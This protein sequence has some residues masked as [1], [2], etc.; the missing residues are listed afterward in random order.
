[1]LAAITALV[2]DGSILAVAVPLLVGGLMLR[3]F[4]TPT[5]SRWRVTAE[6]GW[7][8]SLP[9][10]M[11]G[12]LEVLAAD[13]EFACR[14]VTALVWGGAGAAP[15]PETVQGILG[16]LDT[17]A[18]AQSHEGRG[19]DIRSGPISGNTGIVSNGQMV[20]RNTR[21]V[22]YVHRLVDEVLMPL[23]RSHAIARVSLT[24][25]SCSSREDLLGVRARRRGAP[26]RPEV[27]QSARR[28]SP[29][30]AGT[31][32]LSL[33]NPSETAAELRRP[34]GGR[35]AARPERPERVSCSSCASCPTFPWPP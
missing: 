3:L 31:P 8:A 12:Y 10:A 24:R 29:A 27:V 4:A 2:W 32:A 6:N 30:P 35:A 5:A 20:L 26:Q 28:I 17:D 16:V 11:E 25:E 9:F 19:V 22:P 34:P 23:H 21:L 18:R 33:S 13:P 15:G 14:L 7:V 1:M